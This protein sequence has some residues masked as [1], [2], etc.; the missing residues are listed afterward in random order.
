[1]QAYQKLRQISM[2]SHHYETIDT[3][4]STDFQRPCVEGALGCTS[5]GGLPLDP[6]CQP[7]ITTSADHYSLGTALANRRLGPRLPQ[8]F[9]CWFF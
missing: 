2:T 9:L 1:M 5:L 6:H 7:Y 8:H 3:W 4:T